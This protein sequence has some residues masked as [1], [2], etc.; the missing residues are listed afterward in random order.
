MSAPSAS[1]AS[2]KSA[3]VPEL[4]PEGKFRSWGRLS[5][6]VIGTYVVLL[7]IIVFVLIPREPS[8]SWW[9]PYALAIL[10][11]LFLGRYFSTHYT[12][13]DSFLRASRIL[14]GRRVPL[15]EVRRIEYSALRDLAPSGLMAALGPWG[16]RGR[17]WSPVIGRFDSIFTDPANGILVTGPEYP[18]YFS[19]RDPEA[20]AR[21]LS[22][23]VRSYT[24]PL[25]VDV[26][27][28]LSG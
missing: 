19:P 20:F 28:P 15:E 8:S 9:V 24:G 10:I 2:A 16:W 23:R 14:G 5:V 21:E 12:I 25:E 13:D 4:D 27:H 3:P 17:M 18:L 1:P 7:L 22:R 26:G 6:G 11:A